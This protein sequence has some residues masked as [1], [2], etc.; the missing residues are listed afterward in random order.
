M[1]KS[2][3]K[4]LSRGP[5]LPIFQMIA[6]VRR[7]PRPV[8]PRAGA[9]SP[10][11]VR[12]RPGAERAQWATKGRKLVKSRTTGR[13]F[14]PAAALVGRLRY[15][16]KFL[17]VGLVLLI[18]LGFVATAYVQLQNAQRA[19]SGKERTGVAYLGPLFDLTVVAEQARHRAVTDPAGAPVALDAQVARVDDVDGRLRA[20]LGTGDAWQAARR[21]VLAAQRPAGPPQTR[22]QAYGAAIGALLGLIVQVGDASNLTL[23]PDLDTYY[24]MDTLQF[25][26]PALLD[27]AGSSVDLAVLARSEPASTATDA[28]IRIGLANGAM[29]TTQATINRAV[30]TITARTADPGVRRRVVAVAR[31][32]NAATG[33]LAGAL[34]TVVKSRRFTG[35]QPGA[36]EEVQRAAAA[37]AVQA[38]GSL[39]GLLQTRIDGFSARAQR[40]ELASG[41]AALLGGYLF[42][43]FYLSI[44]TPIRRIVATLDSVAAGDLTRRVTVDTHDELSF[45][46]RT[47][48]ETVAR[49][50]IATNRLA[51]QAT[52]DSLTGLPNR[53]AV[54]DRL[55]CALA[56]QQHTG[57]LLAVLFI[58]LDGFKPINDSLG[59]HAGDEVLCAVAARLRVL[60][61]EDDTVGR[62]AGD[63][64]VVVAESF[65]TPAAAVAAAERLVEELSRPLTVG[66]G[67]GPREVSVGASVGLALA[68]RTAGLMPDD[69]LRDADVAMYRAKQRGRGRVEVFDDA[70]QVAV[71]QRLETQGDLRRALGQGEL[72]PHYQ[73]IVDGGTGTILGFEALARWLHP[74]RGLLHPHDFIPVAEETGLIVPVGAEILTQA[75]GHAARWLSE[76][77]A[78]PHLRM[79]VNVAGAQIGHPSFVPTV[80]GALA[81]TG[82]APDALWLEITETT[83]MA[84]AAAAKH[85][86]DVIRAYGVH[87]AIDD[88]G[89]GYSSLTHLRRLPVEALKIDRSFVAG[90]G[91]NHEDEAIVAMIA[92]LARELGLHVV[93]EG[94]ETVDQVLQLRRLGCATLQGFYFGASMPA[95]GVRQLLRA[96]APQLLAG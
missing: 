44:T 15:A 67:I 10:C 91:R 2:G 28:L 4:P 5:D 14:A 63:E 39:D 17:V 27:D 69:L 36:A 50:E 78:F 26:L 61:R 72:Q 38:A 3:R 25:R 88:F 80:A 79:T 74:T 60:L 71:A 48:N 95:E 35:V 90:I 41:L 1:P 29:T 66:A 6:C 53:V 47:L 8:R 57:G 96:A 24:L 59:H 51:R 18:P 19:F 68:D 20:R 75:C 46:A 85:T 13:L 83:I 45:V 11:A 33:R 70:L 52:H 23:D 30:A 62:L 92:T 7:S 89:T 31:P 81:Q 22:F 42:V 73:P 21:L 16:Q 65:A 49:T 87:L 40:V 9:A 37:F 12:D 34:T 84:D 64:F 82:L 32:L 93:A 55:A 56:R 54:L 58:D 77:P 43:G 86:L 94:V 76:F